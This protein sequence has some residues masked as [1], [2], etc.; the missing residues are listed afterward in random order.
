MSRPER[1][2]AI[3]FVVVAMISGCAP[4]TS[5]WVKQLNNPDP[6][7]RV[8]AA[9]ALGE[10]EPKDAP[11]AVIALVRALDREQSDFR[12]RV[13]SSLARQ[14]PVALPTL[15]ASIPSL[16]PGLPCRED[17]LRDALE[18]GRDHIVPLLV[19]SLGD[20]GSPVDD[21]TLALFGWFRN[22]PIAEIVQ[23]L[24]EDLARSSPRARARAAH[25]LGE[26]TS[27]AHPA[28]PALARLLSDDDPGV[29]NEAAKALSRVDVNEP[30]QTWAARL[31][32]PIAEE[33]AAAEAHLCSEF[34]SAVPA[35]VADLEDDN[36]A[37]ALR[38][39]RALSVLG[40]C[41]E[42]RA[43][44]SSLPSS[45]QPGATRALELWK[46]GFAGE[47][48]DAAIEALRA[49]LDEKGTSVRC[50]AALALGLLERRAIAAKPALASLA[51][52]GPPVVR[53]AARLALHR[54]HGG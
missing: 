33:R 5:D 44:C 43:R 27:A 1:S 9:V 34:A 22:K 32:S 20:A 40:D 28:I 25:A 12:P 19:A 24:S 31:K 48:D 21:P 45:D 41:A 26:M 47:V 36:Q 6:F 53:D 17:G 52:K 4:A 18:E 39:L 14:I 46:T 42:A 8:M 49:A 23:F 37:V 16:V 7:R 35:F 3:A 54:I 10:V 38:A 29:R 50:C 13:V 51:V 30:V 2:G 15:A 11:E